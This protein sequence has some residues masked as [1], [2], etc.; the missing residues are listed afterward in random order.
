MKEVYN[1]EKS[2]SR[3]KTNDEFNNASRLRALCDARGGGH[4]EN[5]MKIVQN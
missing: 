5:G 4:I 1:N 3:I 2:H